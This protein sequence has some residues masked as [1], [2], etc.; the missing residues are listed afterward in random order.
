[1]PPAEFWCDA[2]PDTIKNWKAGDYCIVETNGASLTDIFSSFFTKVFFF[3]DFMR[4]QFGIVL[5]VFHK[6]KLVQKLL[7]KML[8]KLIAG[9]NS[10]IFLNNFFCIKVFT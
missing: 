5:V 8:V 3:A 6:K 1:M 2:L 7:A 4:I 9:V 10:T